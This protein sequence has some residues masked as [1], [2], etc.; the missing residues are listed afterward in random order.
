MEEE[1]GAVGHLVL[2]PWEVDEEGMCVQDTKV[3]HVMF[4]IFLRKNI[5][6]ITP[7]IPRQSAPCLLT[8]HLT[9]SYGPMSCSLFP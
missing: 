4:G 7:L 9:R 5:A 2:P 3:T 6:T 8:Y 1:E